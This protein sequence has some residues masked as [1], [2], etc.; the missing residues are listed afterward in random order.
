M[1][2]YY[3]TKNLYGSDTS[4]GFANTWTVLVFTDKTSRDKYIDSSNDMSVNAINK[5][6]IKKYINA[7]KP[8][9]GKRRA[10]NTRSSD[11]IAPFYGTIELM[12]PY[13]GVDL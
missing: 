7:A 5:A 4:V 8:F 11:G 3:A 13:E 10:I 9:S 2:Y 6:D 12:Y 1:K